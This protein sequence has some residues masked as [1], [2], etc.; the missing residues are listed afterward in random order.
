MF[1][2]MQPAAGGGGMFAGMQR[3]TAARCTGSTGGGPVKPKRQYVAGYTRV[4]CD[5][6]V[7]VGGGGGGAGER[8]WT[9]RRAA[10]KRTSGKIRWSIAQHLPPL[11]NSLPD[12]CC[13]S[14]SYPIRQQQCGHSSV[15]HHLCEDA[16]PQYFLEGAGLW[17]AGGIW[18]WHLNCCVHGF[19]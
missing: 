7:V 13:V 9:V 8:S 10:R 12:R 16:E 19:I 15:S 5:I 1:A 18:R 14:G 17:Q 3:A 2:G 6:F 11:W 4:W